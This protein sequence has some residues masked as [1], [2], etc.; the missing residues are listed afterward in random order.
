MELWNDSD[1]SKLNQFIIIV[2]PDYG[3]NTPVR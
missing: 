2:L 1:E 3:C